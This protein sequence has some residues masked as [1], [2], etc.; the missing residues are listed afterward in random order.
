MAL[1][2]ADKELMKYFNQLNEPQKAIIVA[3]NQKNF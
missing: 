1:S 3:N 2:A